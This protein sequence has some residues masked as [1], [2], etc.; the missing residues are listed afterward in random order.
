MKKTD[1][2]K[3]KS[4]KPKKKK[5]M[6]HQSEAGKGDRPRISISLQEWSNRWDKVFG[7]GKKMEKKKNENTTTNS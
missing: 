1:E 4:E 5:T 3:K 2:A 7:A 6:F